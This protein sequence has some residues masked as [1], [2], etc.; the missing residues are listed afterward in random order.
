[1]EK[2]KNQES[3]LHLGV[4]QPKNNMNR[5]KWKGFYTDLKNLQTKKKNKIPTISRKSY[6]TPVLV[7]KIFK[8]HSGKSFSKITISKNMI[9]HKFGEFVATRAKF[10]FKKKKKR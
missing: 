3:L 4:N 10:I 7:G 9:G 5:S 2:V 1:M 8:V 6:I